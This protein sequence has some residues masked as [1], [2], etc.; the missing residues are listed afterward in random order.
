MKKY[1]RLAWVIVLFAVLSCKKKQDEPV[2][3]DNM[4]CN[5]VLP[6]KISFTLSSR[7]WCADA[8]CFA[9]LAIHLT[10]NGIN[11][12]ASS[13]TLEL[14]SL[15]P[16]TYVIN[17]ETNHIL[18]TNGNAYESTNANPGT[19]VITSNDETR[20]VLKGTFSVTLVSPIL[21]NISINNGTFD[22]LYTE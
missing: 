9:D 7:S 21:G 1:S 13:I 18:Y 17:N 4:E 8:S 15:R 10:A 16:G 22:L 2:Y 19:L 14:D 6:S 3:G 5:S 11:S 12:N 20:N